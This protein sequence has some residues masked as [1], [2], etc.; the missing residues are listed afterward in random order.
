M[1]FIFNLCLVQRNLLCRSIEQKTKFL[2]E[3]SSIYKAAC[4]C[5]SGII[6]QHMVL[7]QV[8]N[9]VK[10]WRV[11]GSGSHRDLLHG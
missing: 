3:F 9:H 10:V 1:S 2:T 7:V 8:L 11:V 4:S 5:S 6:V